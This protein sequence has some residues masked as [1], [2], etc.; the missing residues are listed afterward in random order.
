MVR[1]GE[2]WWDTRV[3]LPGWRQV[4]IRRTPRLRKFTKFR[5][6]ASDHAAATSRPTVFIG[7]H[8]QAGI[9]EVSI[10]ASARCLEDPQPPE[11]IVPKAGRS[12]S[13]LDLN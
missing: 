6:R 2:P 3:I 1:S 8:W 12:I 11:N 5:P 13:C 4:L 10:G 7:S 9:S